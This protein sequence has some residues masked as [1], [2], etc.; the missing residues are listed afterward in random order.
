MLIHGTGVFTTVK[1]H[2]KS[3]NCIKRLA[4]LSITL[5]IHFILT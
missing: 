5:I 2:E 4:Q 1:K 3:S